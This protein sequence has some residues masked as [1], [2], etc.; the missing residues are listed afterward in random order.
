[1]GNPYIMTE[2]KLVT[3]GQEPG[4]RYLMSCITTAPSQYGVAGLTAVLKHKS[5]RLSFLSLMIG[6]V[7]NSYVVERCK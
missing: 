1:M 5:Q 4:V 3:R 2:Y 7:T 6:V